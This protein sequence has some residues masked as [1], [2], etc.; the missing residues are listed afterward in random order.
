L[1]TTELL[2]SFAIALPGFGINIT[3]RSCSSYTIVLIIVHDNIIVLTRTW[4]LT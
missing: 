3:L 2:G 1:F 4:S